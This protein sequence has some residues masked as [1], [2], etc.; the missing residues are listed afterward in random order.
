MKKYIV[1]RAIEK[2]NKRFEAKAVVT[3][4]QLRN[5]PVQDWLQSGVLKEVTDNGN[6]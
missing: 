5:W 6:G 3:A 2:G 4:S 1:I